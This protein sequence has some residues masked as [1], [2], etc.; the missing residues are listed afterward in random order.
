MSSIRDLLDLGK[1][2]KDIIIV[3][4]DINCNTDAD[5]FANRY[6]DFTPSKY[7]PGG[8]AL[9]KNPEHPG[10]KTKIRWSRA[11]FEHIGKRNDTLY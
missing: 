6:N 1:E 11:F 5:W 7:S 10:G 9:V 2:I 4:I 8:Y 3:S